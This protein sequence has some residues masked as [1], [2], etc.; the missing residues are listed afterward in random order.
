MVRKVYVWRFVSQQAE[1]THAV[2]ERAE[3]DKYLSAIC[4]V[5]PDFRSNGWLG[6]VGEDSLKARSLKHCARCERTLRQVESKKVV[7][8]LLGG[9][10]G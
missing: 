8:Q 2:L 7:D 5:N 3:G 1:R 9:S 10:N 4:G 6:K